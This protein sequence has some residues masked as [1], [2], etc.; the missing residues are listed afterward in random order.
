MGRLLCT[1]KEAQGKILLAQ[2][3]FPTVNV[4]LIFNFPFQTLE[5]FA[6][7]ISIFKKL[8][9]DQVT[10]YPL[11]PSPHKKMP[12]SVNFSSE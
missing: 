3:Q 5:K 1:G 10:F 4:D 8:G 11:M 6:E 9:L 2:G 7:D 12:W